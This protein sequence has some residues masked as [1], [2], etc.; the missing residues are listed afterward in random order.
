MASMDARDSVASVAS[1]AAVLTAVFVM[2]FA[3]V[4]ERM[5]ELEYFRPSRHFPETAEQYEEINVVTGPR[6]HING[7]LLR[8][9][10][11]Y[12]KIVLLC[13]GNAS[14]VAKEE[15]RMAGLRDL[16]YA[17][18]AF[19]Y[20]GYGKSSGVPSER[21]MYKD[22]SI[23][24][25]LLLQTHEPNEIVLY[26]FSIGAPVAAYVAGRYGIPTLVLES[27]LSS[28]RE[29][30]RRRYRFMGFIAELCPEFDT[31]AHLARFHGAPSKLSQRRRSLVMHGPADEIVPY[32]SVGKLIRMCTRH[33]QIGGT[34]DR[35]VLPWEQIGEFIGAVRP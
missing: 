28:M 8:P 22:A 18:L 26:G 1:I 23:M 5:K 14:N 24:L 3:A 16:G 11:G 27:P 10:S 6:K 7:R 17:V 33:I 32:E 34:H 9:E 25:A 13:H 4:V 31:A 12:S 2:A 30:M 19:D 15:W 20:S 21:Q 35:P 29:V